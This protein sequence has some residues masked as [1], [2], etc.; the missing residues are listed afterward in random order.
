MENTGNFARLDSSAPLSFAET[1]SECNWLRGQFPRFPSREFFRRLRE[2][3]RANRELGGAIRDLASSVD[4][5]RKFRFINLVF[6]QIN[7]DIRLSPPNI[8]HSAAGFT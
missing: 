2:L 4:D 7:P 3:K 6:D 1:G 5:V 8:T